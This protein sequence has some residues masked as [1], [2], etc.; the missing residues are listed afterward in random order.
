[1]FDRILQCSILLAV[2]VGGVPDS[3]SAQYEPTFLP[4]VRQEPTLPIN[5]IFTQSI[6]SSNPDP[7]R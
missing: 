3:A 6:S 5:L 4:V 7:F 1:M 2:L